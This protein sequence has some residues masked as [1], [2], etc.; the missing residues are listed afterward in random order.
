VTYNW[1]P[2][3][4]SSGD[5]ICPYEDSS[6]NQADIFVMNEKGSSLVVEESRCSHVATLGFDKNK[7]VTAGHVN[8]RLKVIGH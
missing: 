7:T 3:I 5:H 1:M 2:L 4:T 6:L 8:K